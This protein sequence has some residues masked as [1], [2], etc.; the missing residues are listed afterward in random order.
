[1]LVSFLLLGGCAHAPLPLS[2]ERL[3]ER[4]EL[5]GVPFFAQRS[6]QGAPGA[7]AMALM[8]QGVVTTPGL[9]AEQLQLPKEQAQIE[10]NLPKIVQGH[11]L[12]VYPLTAGLPEMLAQ[13]T[14][15]FPVLLR[16][17][18]GVGWL[19][20][21]RYAVLVGYDRAE[22]T[23]LL[24]SGMHR[25]ESI[26]FA[27]FQSAWHSAGQWSVLVQAPAQLPAEV[28]RVRWLKAA[29]A[30]EGAGQALAASN[31]YLTLERNNANAVTTP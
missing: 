1:M 7:L 9:I 22:Q 12:L 24:R 6:Y 3:P 17:T 25:R 15:G 31:A 26:D 14:A 5:I 30:L 13:V 16:Y 19:S 21:P 23:L 20:A 10:Q 29:A 4:V 11:G 2:I 18:Q 28:D 27:E 8:Q